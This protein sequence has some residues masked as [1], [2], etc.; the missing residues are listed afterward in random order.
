MCDGIGAGAEALAREPLWRRRRG[1]VTVLLIGPLA[2]APAVTEWN[3]LREARAA[4][5]AAGWRP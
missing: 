1:L 5:T 4:L 3:N 2:A